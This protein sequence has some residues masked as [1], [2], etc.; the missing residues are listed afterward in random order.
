[1]DLYDAHRNHRDQFEILAFHDA[2]A[3]DFAELD[4]K[5]KRVIQNQ[6]RGKPLPFP[7][8]LD[9]TGQTI[10]EYG[11][12]SFPTTIL[13]DPDGKLVGQV[14][15][16]ALEE[17]LPALPVAERVTRALD[18]DIG[19]GFDAPALSVVTKA[20]GARARID[21][22]FGEGALKAAGVTPETTVPLT[23]SGSVSLRSW[24]DLVLGPFDL[25]FGRDDK[26]LVIVHCKGGPDRI[27]EPSEPQRYRAQRIEGRLDETVTF[28]FRAKTLAQVAQFFASLT[29]ENFVLD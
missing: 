4:G 18:R 1:M 16:Y 22:R 13:I 8:L 26:G 25:T 27:G 29:R 6:W 3:Q 7:I 15:D 21:I 23:L 24:L 9:A 5:L 28:D 2:T 11:V 17:K 19:Y 14:G 20:L 10:K 12:R